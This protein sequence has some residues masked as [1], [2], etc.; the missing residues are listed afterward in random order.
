V[1]DGA[2]PAFLA[3]VSNIN[4]ARQIPA[5]TGANFNIVNDN[6][7]T[8]RMLGLELAEA[9]A[10]SALNTTGAKNLLIGDMSQYVVVVDRLPMVMIFE[11]LVFNA[12]PVPTGQQRVVLLRQ[13]GR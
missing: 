11:P 10:M 4:V 6:R 2:R 9:S 1:Y 5:F 8:P 13:G 7:D 3:N 12:T